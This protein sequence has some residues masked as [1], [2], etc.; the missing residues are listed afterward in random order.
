MKDIC[1]VAD[2]LVRVREESGHT[3]AE[4]SRDTRISQSILS[5]YET[6]KM[7]PTLMDAIRLARYYGID[8]SEFIDRITDWVSIDPRSESAEVA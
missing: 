1:Y 6:G 2:G 7:P 5:R 4:A 8:Y 3:Q